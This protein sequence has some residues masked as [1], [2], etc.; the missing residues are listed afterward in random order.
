MVDI[1]AAKYGFGESLISGIEKLNSLNR[2]P[3]KNIK[4]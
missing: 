2:F 4:K 1:T 3:A